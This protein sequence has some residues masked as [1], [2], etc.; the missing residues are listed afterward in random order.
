MK[1]KNHKIHNT[2]EAK[3]TLDVLLMRKT[4]KTDGKKCGTITKMVY[5]NE[6]LQYKIRTKPS[7][8]SA[9][10]ILMLSKPLLSTNF[11]ESFL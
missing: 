10:Y 11:T 3:I 8:P 6:W 7:K 9:I 1:C 2:K 4:Q 5:P